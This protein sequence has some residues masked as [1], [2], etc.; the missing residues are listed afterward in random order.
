MR[1]RSTSLI[2]YVAYGSNLSER[3]FQCYLDGTR[4]PGAGRAMRGARDARPPLRSEP[5]RLSG[6]LRFGG[7]SVVWNGGVA[8]YDPDGEGT[9]WGRRYLLRWSQ[10]EDVFAQENASPTEPVGLPPDPS[11]EHRDGRYRRLVQLP[12]HDGVPA[13][14]FTGVSRPPVRAPSRDYLRWV[15]A[16]LREGHAADAGTIADYLGRADGVSDRWSRRE[17]LDLAGGR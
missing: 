8:Y 5:C 10:F 15:I 11:L 14:S 2:W 17:L 9:V 6:G 4:P 3:R 1:D 13:V 12:D 16:G 7:H